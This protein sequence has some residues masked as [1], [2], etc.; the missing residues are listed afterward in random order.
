MI[1]IVHKATRQK[2]KPQKKE[3]SKIV[4]SLY[5]TAV[6]SWGI[7]PSEFW[8][9]SPEEFWWIAEQKNPQAF[10]EPERERLLR[11]LENGFG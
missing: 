7:S 6:G 5:M 10:Q 9:M 11:L 3:D 4:R 1:V 8:A 2:T